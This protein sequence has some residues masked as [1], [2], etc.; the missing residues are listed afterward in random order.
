MDCW[1]HSWSAISSTFIAIR[2]IHLYKL[3]QSCFSL[4]RSRPI[5]TCIHEHINCNSDQCIGR[6]F[7]NSWNHCMQASILGFLFVCLQYLFI[8]L[9]NRFSCLW[10]THALFMLSKNCWNGFQTLCNF[11]V[12]LSAVH[13]S[14][15]TA[16]FIVQSILHAGFP[17]SGKS[18]NVLES[19][20]N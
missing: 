13:A 6:T 16:Y 3:F 10:C 8:P 5:Y 9:R 14:L 18:L 11:V 2:K 4:G 1:L 19:P 17:L 7:R 20:G 15:L 12:L